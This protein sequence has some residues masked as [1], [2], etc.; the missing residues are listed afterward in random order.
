MDPLQLSEHLS[1]N[2]ESD[3]KRHLSAAQFEERLQAFAVP[4]H[5]VIKLLLEVASFVLLHY[6]IVVDHLG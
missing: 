1:G 2:I 5:H 3:L 6:K 4:G